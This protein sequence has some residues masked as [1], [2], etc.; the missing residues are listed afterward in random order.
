MAIAGGYAGKILKVDLSRQAV[1]IEPLPESLVERFL[2]GAGV[3]A[4]L[5]YELLEP[6]EDPFSPGN[7]M[8]FGAGPMVGTMVPG[9]GKCN[10]TS[11]SPIKKFMGISGHGLFG[12]LKFAG[13]DHL[14]ISGRADEPVYLKIE[15]DE[16]TFCP[17]GHLWGQDVFETTDAIWRESGVDFHVSCIGPAGE[18]LVRD[19]AV[20]TNKYAAFARTGM[21]AV[22]GSKNL[23]GIAL[24]GTRSIGVA[25]RL[26]FLKVVKKLFK[27]VHAHPNFLDWRKYG[28]LISLEIFARLGLYASR[29]YQNAFDESLLDTFSFDGFISEVKDG[30]IACLACPVGCKHRLKDGKGGSAQTSLCIS[31]MN[32]V[33]QSFGN[34]CLIRGWPEV[35]KCA[36]TAVRMGLDF[37]SLGNLA[38]FAMELQQRGLLDSSL[39]SDLDLKWGD[40]E[41]VRELTRKIAHREGIGDILADGLDEAART[42]GPETEKF[43]LHSKGLGVLYDPRVK[44][45]STEIF[46]QFTNIRGYISNVSVA[47]VPRTQDQIRRYC[48]KIGLPQDAIDRIT[49][50]EGYNVA[51]LNKW[52]EDVTSV[53]ELLGVCEFPIYQRLPFHLW[54]DLYTAVTGIE[55]APSKLIQI[56]EN[57]W[58]L[59]R[60]LNLRQG[61]DSSDDTCPERFFTESVTFGDRQMPPVNRE[62]FDQLRSDYYDERGWDKD[63][64]VPSRERL[65]RLG[66]T[67]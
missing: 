44:L 23:K 13:F 42:L 29:N 1:S 39:S 63:T 47:M 67:L 3:N 64:G 24:Y 2:G 52:T 6:G 21:G 30:D 11:R 45:D 57:F 15:N 54:A 17:A 10:L 35:A 66:I 46:S 32:S 12:M 28:T 14:I 20:I 61:A 25:D 38:A 22:M 65:E 16:V 7:H 53:M 31:C 48:T 33:M 41:S 37:M 19:A 4:A 34:F 50:G 40:G 58:D 55:M 60:A 59:R 49:Q 9:A 51:R 62:H 8:I 27:G 36:E 18:H 5:A 26:Q 43:A 56:S